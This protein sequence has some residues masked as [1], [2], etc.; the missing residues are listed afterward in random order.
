[1]EKA[2]ACPLQFDRKQSRILSTKLVVVGVVA[3]PVACINLRIKN[4]SE[5]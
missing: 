2:S 4:K 5:L 1:M 3:R